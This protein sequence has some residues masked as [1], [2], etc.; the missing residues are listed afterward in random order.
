MGMP[1]QLAPHPAL[2]PNPSHG[3]TRRNLPIGSLRRVHTRPSHDQRGHHGQRKKQE[4]DFRRVHDEETVHAAM[5]RQAGPPHDDVA[6]DAAQRDRH[7]RRRGL[8]RAPGAERQAGLLARAPG[9]SSPSACRGRTGP[10]PKPIS[11][12]PSGEQARGRAGAPAAMT[13]RKA[14]MPT[15]APTAAMRNG[16]KPRLSTREASPKPSRP[17]TASVAVSLVVS[18]HGRGAAPAR[19]RARAARPPC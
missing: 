2:E 3:R 7:A 16:S 6:D 5:G 9:S 12:V 19:H 14:G 11:S 17:P 13:A 15:S 4:Q 8:H 10:P 18:R 1:D